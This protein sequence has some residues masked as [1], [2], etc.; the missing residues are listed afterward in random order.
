MMQ[1]KIKAITRKMMATVSELAMHQAD[2]MYLQ[3][4]VSNT[5]PFHISHL[6]IFF[7]PL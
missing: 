4:T 3:K 1:S 7:G 5:F 6:L 2:G